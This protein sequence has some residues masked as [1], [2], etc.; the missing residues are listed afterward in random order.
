MRFASV[1]EIRNQFIKISGRG[2][3]EKG[4]YFGDQPWKAHA[5]I[6]PISERE[7]ETLDWAKLIEERLQPAWSADEDELYDYRSSRPSSR[8]RCSN[9]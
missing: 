1:A 4:A 8:E 2:K 9:F 5:L 6:Q 7:L 3:E